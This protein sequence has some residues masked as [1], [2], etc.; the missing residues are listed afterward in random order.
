MQLHELKPNHKQKKSK[1]IGRG[2]K[3]GAFSGKGQKG[4]RSR[5]GRRFK[6]AIRELIKKYPKLRGYK[7][8]RFKPGYQV[9]SLETLE[10]TFN[11]GQTVSPQVLLEKRLIRRIK[12]KTLKIKILGQGEITKVLTIENCLTSKQA[13][14]KIEKAGGKIS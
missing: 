4:Q 5:S 2:G 9:I 3:K 14:D 13:K 7:F 12:G 1:R 6:P 8:N 10:K 11:S